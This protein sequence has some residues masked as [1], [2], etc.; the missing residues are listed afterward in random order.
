MQNPR[1]AERPSITLARDEGRSAK[2]RECDSR[3]SRT[4]YRV[5]GALT[6]K[7]ADVWC[8]VTA[9]FCVNIRESAPRP[10]ESE[11]DKKDGKPRLSDVAPVLGI[12]LVTSLMAIVVAVAMKADGIVFIALAV[13]LTALAVRLRQGS[14]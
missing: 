7:T 5:S 14:S 9:A 3:I 11:L 6:V 1:N 12:C 8:K 2:L 13:V 10:E 4:P